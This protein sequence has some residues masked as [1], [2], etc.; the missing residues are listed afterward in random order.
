MG[1]SVERCTERLHRA[2]RDRLIRSAEEA[3]HLASVLAGELDRW[4]DVILA[5][6]PRQ[7]VEAD[8]AVEALLPGSPG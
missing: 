5:P 4:I 7:A 2:S 3:G 8:H 1:M 6:A